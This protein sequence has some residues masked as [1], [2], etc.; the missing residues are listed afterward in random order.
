M[1]YKAD[2]SDE[3]LK[4]A[5]KLKKKDLVLFKRLESKINEIL[6]RPQHYKP[7]KSKMKGLRSVHVGSFVVILEINNKYVK[8]VTFKHHDKAYI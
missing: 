4:I 5:K 6:E 2:F 8:F 1:S 3:F 7:L